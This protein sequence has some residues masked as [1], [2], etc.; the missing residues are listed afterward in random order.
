MLLPW[1]PQLHQLLVKSVKFGMLQLLHNPNTWLLGVKGCNLLTGEPAPDAAYEQ[2]MASVPMEVLP[3]DF[4]PKLRA[5]LEKYK[6]AAV[7]VLQRGAELQRRLEQLLA[8][9]SHGAGGQGM[10]GEG[11]AQAVDRRSSFGSSGNST[12]SGDAC[13]ASPADAT[14]VLSRSSNAWAVWRTLHSPQHWSHSLSTPMKL[15]GGRQRQS[16]CSII[17][18]VLEA[19]DA[20]QDTIGLADQLLQQLQRTFTELLYAQTVIYPPEYFGAG[21][22]QCASTTQLLVL[23]CLP[24]H[25]DVPRVAEALC[26]RAMHG[27]AASQ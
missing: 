13:N 5:G 1:R 19:P 3:V 15:G 21:P 10:A 24:Y 22:I 12:S 11:D 23:A 18:D 25:F 20:P 4:I 9:A 2:A 27:H 14:A 16:S 8:S 26:A 17:A 6:A 7:G